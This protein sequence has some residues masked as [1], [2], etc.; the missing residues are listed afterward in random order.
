[1]QPC[2]T[3]PFNT[4]STLINRTRIINLILKYEGK[5]NVVNLTPVFSENA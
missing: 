5:A 4:D 1:M 2:W 3:G